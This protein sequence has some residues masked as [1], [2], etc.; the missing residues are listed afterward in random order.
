MYS[1][2]LGKN[3]KRDVAFLIETLQPK[4]RYHRVVTWAS[5]TG[6]QLTES[7]LDKSCSDRKAI[8]RQ[9]CF[10]SSANRSERICDWNSKNPEQSYLVTL[11]FVIA[12]NTEIVDSKMLREKGRYNSMALNSVKDYWEVSKAFKK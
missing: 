8:T 1:K 9:E 12:R 10:K 3:E 7:V 11:E 5:V 2:L 4:Q 6:F